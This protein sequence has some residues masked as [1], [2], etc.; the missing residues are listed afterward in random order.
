MEIN[1][2]EK[3]MAQNWCEQFIENTLERD[4]WRAEEGLAEF[5]RED[6]VDVV[7][8][9]GFGWTASPQGYG[10]WLRRCTNLPCYKLAR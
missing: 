7:I 5:Y 10:V 6:K 9:E 4:P 2:F 3:V 8:G 1:G